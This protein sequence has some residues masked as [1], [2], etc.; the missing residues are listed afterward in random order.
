MGPQ[1]G[2]EKRN[3]TSP[4]SAREVCFCNARRSIL[5][6]LVAEH[7]APTRTRIV[8]VTAELWSLVVTQPQRSY[9]RVE[10]QHCFWYKNIKTRPRPE[11]KPG[12]SLCESS[13]PA[14]AEGAGAQLESRSGSSRY[15]VALTQKWLAGMRINQHGELNQTF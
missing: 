5:I 13:C 8:H 12:R 14:S 2:V 11:L 9:P 7:Q 15:S 6:I 10:A 4:H 3:K 1:L